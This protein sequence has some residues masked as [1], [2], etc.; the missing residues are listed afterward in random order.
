MF[1]VFEDDFRVMTVRWKYRIFYK[2][3][4]NQKNVIIEYIFWSEEN[5]QNLIH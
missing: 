2:V 5:Y 1:P 4:E 3:D